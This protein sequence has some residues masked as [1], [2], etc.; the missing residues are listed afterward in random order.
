MMKRQYSKA[1]NEDSDSEEIVESVE[2]SED[3][4][5]EESVEES[6]EEYDENE[7]KYN[8]ERD[9]YNQLL[10]KLYNKIE[11]D[12]YNDD[13]DLDRELDYKKMS[14]ELGDI[15]NDINKDENISITEIMKNNKL[16][17]EG[18]KDL[19]DKFIYMHTDGEDEYFIWRDYI[20]FRLNG[21]TETE[22]T[23]TTKI[24]ESKMD[25]YNK[26]VVMNKYLRMKKM[27]KS[28]N[29]YGKLNEWI[30]KVLSIP[31]GVY[32]DVEVNNVNEYLENAR[33][34][35]DT[36]IMNM[37]EA[38]DEVINYIAMMVKNK[39]SVGKVLSLYG[40]K[41]CG[42][43][44]LIKDGI[45]KV[46]DRPFFYIAL[47]GCKDSS[48]L[49]GHGY[50]YEGALPGKI[51]QILVEAK[52]MNP[53]IYFDELDK[54]SEARGGQDIMGVLTHLID[55]VQ[56]MN[57]MD[58]YFDGIKLD[59]SKATFI[60]SYNDSSKCDEIVLD[61]IKQIKVKTPTVDEKVNI[62]RNNLILNIVKEYSIEKEIDISD[63]NI[64]YLITKTD[65]LGCRNLKRYLE[66]IIIRL[67]NMDVTS[68]IVTKDYKKISEDKYLT[69]LIIDRDVIDLILE[70]DFNIEKYH[71]MYT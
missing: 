46:L 49:K 48:F 25:E 26:K 12:K 39:K 41:G 62:A 61:R 35:L 15:V 52:C 3:E 70:K 2:E 27:D 16:N 50:T 7:I 33:K 29:E 36:N 63:E 11:M 6:L 19:I 45:S 34:V 14:E 9:P 59:L 64:K 65:E 66:D 24:Q 54:V 18:K 38:K 40:E 4:S 30:T 68:N 69:K 42:K 51:S 5:G 23:L 58:Y 1:F 43:T 32:N 21:L 13:D 55:P 57:F 31:F 71:S 28:A 44:S 10:N 22:D 53:I 47:G 37:E 8:D 20:K 67:N 60:F 17:K 56:N